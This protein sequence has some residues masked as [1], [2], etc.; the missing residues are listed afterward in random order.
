[1]PNLFRLSMSI[2]MLFYWIEFAK[3]GEEIRVWMP[4]KITALFSEL[5]SL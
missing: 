3:S 4:F 5:F 2:D 1:M